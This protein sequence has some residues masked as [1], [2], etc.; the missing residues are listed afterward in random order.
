[1]AYNDLAAIAQAV[2]REKY[3]NTHVFSTEVLRGPAVLFDDWAQ[4]NAQLTKAQVR[5][6]K[7]LFTD[8]EWMLCQKAIFQATTIPECS[9][10][11]DYIYANAKKHVA[12]HW[13]AAENCQS[14]F[15]NEQ[16]LNHPVVHLRLTMGYDL[17]GFSDI[18][19]FV[20]PAHI[21]EAIET[22]QLDLLTWANDLKIEN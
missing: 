12:K 1:M 9:A 10:K 19:D 16:V 2:I 21:Q 6:I 20:V 18:L 8:Y 22:K 11:A 14:S 5:Q 15:K 17:W 4:S 13:L 7:E 3:G